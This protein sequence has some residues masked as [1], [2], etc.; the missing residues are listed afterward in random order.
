MG[1]SRTEAAADVTGL[2]WV[3]GA[4]DTSGRIGAIH[5]EWHAKFTGATGGAK[6]F[7]KGNVAHIFVN[8]FKNGR[9]S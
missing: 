9:K 8:V 7:F 6:G 5:D 1:G 3:L 4:L 2:S